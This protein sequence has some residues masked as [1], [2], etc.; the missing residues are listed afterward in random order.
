MEAV[1]NST[2]PI[3]FLTKTSN[4]PYDIDDLKE[5]YNQNLSLNTFYLIL[6]TIVLILILI[7]VF[8]RGNVVRIASNWPSYRCNPMF[9]PFAFLFGYD[10]N[11]NFNYCM[12]NIFTKH[13]SKSLVPVYGMMGEFTQ[14]S[15]TL[16]K[17]ANSTRSVMANMLL[18]TEK[19]M[20]SYRDRIQ[21]L[22]FTIRMGFIRLKN[23]MGRAYA[24][25]FATMR[26]GDSGKQAGWNIYNS[27][28]TQFLIDM[29]CFDPE[30]PIVLQNG[31]IKKI[32]D[33]Q[34]GDTLSSIDG[35]NPVVTSVFMLN[36]TKTPMV[37]IGDTLV[38]KEHYTFYNNEWIKSG[39]HPDAVDAESIPQLVCLNTDTHVIL[40][41]NNIFSDYDE[42]SDT[43]VAT[44]T[45]ATAEMLLNDGIFDITNETTRLYELGLDPKTLIL[46]KDGSIKPITD[47]KIGDTLM[48]GGTVMGL[49][50]EECSW[51]VTLPNGLIVS[52]SQLIWDTNFVLW[53]RAGFIY[54]HTCIHLDTPIV[55]YQLC[56]SNNYIESDGVSFRDYCEVT[57]PEMEKPYEKSFSEKNEYTFVK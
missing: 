1:V 32:K 19:L 25:Y 15:E 6:L 5:V 22:L 8:F 52:S 49:V 23:L 48:G 13:A 24:T 31:F 35:K 38:S 3:A 11:E 56:V 50:K 41:N 39:E 45:Q 44:E 14:I 33:I 9:M 27:E 40:I 18:G 37:K 34:I 4:T 7:Y 46:C 54:P 16:A 29:F 2:S 30:T 57:H 10:T 17:S 21:Y 53:R 12:K 42:S 47:I 36:G 55:L 51:I 28:F 26:I 43:S 20:S